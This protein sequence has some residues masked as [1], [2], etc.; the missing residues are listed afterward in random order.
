M[1]INMLNYVIVLVIQVI[2]KLY[3]DVSLQPIRRAV[4]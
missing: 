3:C 1:H 2:I 4:V